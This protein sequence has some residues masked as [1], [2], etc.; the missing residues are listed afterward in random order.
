MRNKDHQTTGIQ[1]EDSYVGNKYM[2]LLLNMIDSG[3]IS[4]T[5][6]TQNQD[7]SVSK[8]PSFSKNMEK[9]LDLMLASED[10]LTRALNIKNV[11]Q[12]NKIIAGH[13]SNFSN[14]L[15]NHP[16]LS[17]EWLDVN[18]TMY[19]IYNKGNENPDIYNWEFIDGVKTNTGIN[20]QHEDVQLILQQYNMTNP[21]QLTTIKTGMDF[22]LNA[23]TLAIGDGPNSASTIIHLQAQKNSNNEFERE[24][25]SSRL[26]SGSPVEKGSWAALSELYNY[27]TSEEIDGVD[28]DDFIGRAGWFGKGD[29]EFAYD[30]NQAAF[31]EVSSEQIGGLNTGKQLE[32]KWVKDEKDF[33]LFAKSLG[34]NLGGNYKKT[35]DLALKLPAAR[36]NDKYNAIIKVIEDAVKTGDAGYENHFGVGHRGI[37]NLVFGFEGGGIAD[38]FTPGEGGNKSRMNKFYEDYVIQRIIAHSE[39]YKLATLSSGSSIIEKGYVEV[40]DQSQSWEDDE[41]M[42][43]D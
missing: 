42:I 31:L 4:E 29:S 25:S 6:Y 20:M 32:H 8:I 16:H 35:I 36:A 3:G 5:S 14:A 21:N 27:Y 15:S 10:K 30:A 12:D 41:S 13:M 22:M 34:D 2:K 26:F 17:G 11:T 28:N 1:V 39:L 43:Y 33:T 37:S 7:G 9:Y 23:P 38:M 18:R 24:R 40:E 19:D